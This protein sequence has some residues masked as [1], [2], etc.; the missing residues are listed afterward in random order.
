MENT[1]QIKDLTLQ[2]GVDGNE[3]I[4]IQNNGVTK[5]IKSGEFLW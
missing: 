5:R 1:K 4:L 3:D 2:T